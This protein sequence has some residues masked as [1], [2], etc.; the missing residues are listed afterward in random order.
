MADDTV[1]L[2]LGEVEVEVLE[3][4]L[5]LYLRAR[6]AAADHRY[7][8]RYRVAH[9]ILGTLARPGGGDSAD[10]GGDDEPAGAAVRPTAGRIED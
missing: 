2:V 8:Y 6:P 5:E 3:E 10:P 1:R 9:G 7:D 4:A